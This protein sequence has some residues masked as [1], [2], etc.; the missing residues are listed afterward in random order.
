MYAHL[1]LI[2]VNQN[3]ERISNVLKRFNVNTQ[4]Y[5]LTIILPSDGCLM[6]ILIYLLDGCASLNDT[7]YI[8]LSV[9]TGSRQATPLP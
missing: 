6:A 4:I 3:T 9:L 2:F 7:S 1:D 5:Y 8:R